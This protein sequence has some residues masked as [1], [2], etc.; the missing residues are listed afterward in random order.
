MSCKDELIE[1]AG[2]NQSNRAQLARRLAD[3]LTDE[4]QRKKWAFI[5]LRREFDARGND[6]STSET[7]ARGL[8][9]VAYLAPIGIAWF[10]LRSA[11]TGYRSAVRLLGPNDSINFLAF[12]SGG[13][14][15]KPWENTGTNAS[16]VALQVFISILLIA[17]LHGFIAYKRNESARHA[18]ILDDLILDAS[19][20]LTKARSITPEEMAGVLKV[21]AT[22]LESGLRKLSDGLEA[23]DEVVDR[24]SGL[25]S[26]LG[27]SSLSIQRATDG[28]RATIEPLT[29]FGDAS[30]SAEAA[31]LSASEA[32]GNAESS[33]VTSLGDAIG[34][35]ANVS[36]GTRHVIDSLEAARSGIS[37][38]VA[39][40]KTVSGLGDTTVREFHQLQS[41]LTRN[42]EKAAELVELTTRASQALGA[43]AA[44][45]DS[46]QAHS[47]LIVLQEV[48]NGMDNSARMLIEAVQHVSEQLARWNDARV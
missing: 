26:D 39:A 24:I 7:F 42:T 28:L 8:L 44:S 19:L 18:A 47:F 32:I 46:P 5:D 30:R 11:F 13:Y 21:A 22:D 35:L 16:I 45:A 48:A 12:W 25:V 23:I 40:T 29:K 17:A 9:V 3:V 38:A 34:T 14:E 41:A 1:W 4:E 6:E 15:G 43:V 2:S 31:L 27:T 36:D 37:S 10:H 33:F 20:D